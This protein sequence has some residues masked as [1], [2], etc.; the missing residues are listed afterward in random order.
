MPVS[1][2]ALLAAAAVSVS[3]GV[4]GPE[5]GF[6]IETNAVYPV[7]QARDQYR[8][9]LRG[10]DRDG[11]GTPATNVVGLTPRRGT[12]GRIGVTLAGPWCRGFWRGKVEFR[13]YRPGCRCFVRKRLGTF[14]VEVR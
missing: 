2:V 1:A 11:C 9:A 6:T 7:K 4:G 10:W 14:V 12:R 13:D 5:T 3:P 8:F